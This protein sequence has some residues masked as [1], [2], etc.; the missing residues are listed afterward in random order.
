MFLVDEWKV[1]EI[2]SRFL[3]GYSIGTHGVEKPFMSQ[4][5]VP[6]SDGYSFWLDPENFLPRKN[7]QLEASDQLW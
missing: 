4:R 5:V 6:G 7:P 3:L 1:S 2:V